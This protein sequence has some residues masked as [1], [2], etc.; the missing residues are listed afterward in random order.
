[1]SVLCYRPFMS[2]NVPLTQTTE[3]LDNS[4]IG[5]LQTAYAAMWI[6]HMNGL[7][8]PL[9]IRMASPVRTQRWDSSELSFLQAWS[10]PS[11]FRSVTTK[12]KCLIPLGF[13]TTDYSV[14]WSWLFNF[15]SSTV[16]KLLWYG[17]PSKRNDFLPH[18][19]I[20]LLTPHEFI[21]C[22]L[23]HRIKQW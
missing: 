13:L 1:M 22:N 4:P 12:L 15:R 3:K 17:D 19:W 2:R 14:H 11:V 23:P 7:G 18:P 21:L 8:S 20:K 16:L 9:D 6:A 5:D 10:F